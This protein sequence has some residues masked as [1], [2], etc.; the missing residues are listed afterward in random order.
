MSEMLQNWPQARIAYLEAVKVDPKEQVFQQALVNIDKVIEKQEHIEARKE[1]GRRQQQ[2]NPQNPNQPKGDVNKKNL[3]QP[4]YRAWMEA[5][6]VVGP[7][8][9]FKV[10]G[11][12]ASLQGTSSHVSTTSRQWLVL[13]FSDWV[14]GMKRGIGGLSR[15]LSREA[16]MAFRTIVRD[17][18]KFKSEVRKFEHRPNEGRRK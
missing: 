12:Y 18:P 5:V 15:C 11:K 1:K 2:S 7:G 6:T 4:G 17:K 16:D 10:L 3:E 13:G 8:S 9:A 14:I